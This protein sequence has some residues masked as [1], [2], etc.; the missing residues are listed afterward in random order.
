MIYPLIIIGIVLLI[1]G[2]FLSSTIVWVLGLICV[3]VGVALLL[4]H[5]ARASGAP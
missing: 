2:F 4:I 5:A 3:V 1:V